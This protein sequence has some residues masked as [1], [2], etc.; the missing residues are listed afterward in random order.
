MC[1]KKGSLLE[2]SVQQV[3]QI[4]YQYKNWYITNAILTKFFGEKCSRL[5]WHNCKIFLTDQKCYLNKLRSIYGCNTLYFIEI[6][7]PKINL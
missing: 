5:L 7:L 3:C 1:F 6:I 2:E 4:K